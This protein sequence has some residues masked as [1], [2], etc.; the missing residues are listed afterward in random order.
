MA[1]LNAGTRSVATAR[2]TPTYPRTPLGGVYI[3]GTK[4]IEASIGDTAITASAWIEDEKYG[5]Y[6][7]RSATA[8]SAEFDSAVKR[9]GKFTLKLSTT[10]ATGAVMADITPAGGLANCRKYAIPCKP[11]TTYVWKC[12]VKTNNV[13]TNSAYLQ[14]RTYTAAGVYTD[15][16]ASSLLSGTNDWTLLTVSITT[17]ATIVYLSPALRLYVTGNVS[18]AWFDINSMTLT[19]VLPRNPVA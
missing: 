17:G 12:W 1:R 14:L 6:M 4:S 19:A 3:L 16:P 2:T 15:N 8:V 11:N 7:Y 9:T 18:D 5:W 10:D 13:A